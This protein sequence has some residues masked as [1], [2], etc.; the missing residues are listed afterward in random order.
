MHPTPPLKM[1]STLMHWSWRSQEAVMYTTSKRVRIH[2]IDGWIISSAAW[3][4]ST[5]PYPVC[6]YVYVYLILPTF[7]PTSYLLTTSYLSTYLLLQVAA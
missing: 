2:Q 4:R 3:P 7:L 1:L 5:T 6:S